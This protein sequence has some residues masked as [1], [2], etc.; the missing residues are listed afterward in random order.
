MWA[1]LLF[2]ERTPLKR[3]KVSVSLDVAI[4]LC[5]LK[6]ATLLLFSRISQ[7]RQGGLLGGLV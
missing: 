3:C 7:A 2:A 4:F 5:E 6:L 1:P